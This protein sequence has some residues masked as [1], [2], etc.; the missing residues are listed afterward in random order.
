MQHEMLDRLERRG[1]SFFAELTKGLESDSGESA[2]DAL[3]DLVWRGL[4]TN[5]TFAPLRALARRPS[6]SRRR[7]GS[8][9]HRPRSGHPGPG[10]P[11]SAT[12][13]RWSLVANLLEGAPN[14]T[15]R[16]HA[17][18][19][20]LLDRH[21][22]V[23]REAMAIEDQAGGF[24][25]IY[26]VL[27][28]MEETGRVR[29]GHF[30]AGLSSAQFAAPGAVDRLRSLRAVESAPRAV[31]LAATDP[32]QAYGVQLDWPST[33]RT[34]GRPRRAVGAGVVLV[35]GRPSVFIEA[36]GQ[37]VLTF[38]DETIRVGAERLDL[39]LR[40]L[41]N[42]VGHVGRKRLHIEEID[43]EKARASD[44]AEAFL[45]A[46]FRASYRGFEIDRSSEASDQGDEA[47]ESAD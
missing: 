13:G 18:T 37:R 47:E 35:D 14:P 46:G 16:I 10:A 41:V 9:G 33:R 24:G 38:E 30:V 22:I 3:W 40:T 6:T 34:R 4:V 21:G 19:L 26:P 15:R 20:G 12:A 17:R 25:A 28:E 32:A 27:R 8:P 44:L 11:P 1:A 2:F 43:G 5:D 45:A 29:R 31:W 42:A 36:G 23:S 39:A 7:R